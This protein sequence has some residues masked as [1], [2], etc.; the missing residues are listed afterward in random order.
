MEFL[1]TSELPHPMPEQSNWCK[2]KLQ[3]SQWLDLFDVEERVLAFRGIWGVMEYL[4]RPKPTP[5]DKEHEAGV[6]VK[7]TG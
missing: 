1:T 6:D 2:P 7:M 3:R 4:S 5:G